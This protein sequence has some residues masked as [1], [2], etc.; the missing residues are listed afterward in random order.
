MSV[1]LRPAG[2]DTHV[3]CV[4]GRVES[5]DRRVVRDAVDLLA[6][7]TTVQGTRSADC[8]PAGGGRHALAGDQ[9]VTQ[10]VGTCAGG[11][12]ALPTAS[13]HWRLAPQRPMDPPAAHRLAM[14]ARRD[15]AQRLRW[16]R[17]HTAQKCRTDRA[18][19]DALAR[20]PAVRRVLRHRPNCWSLGLRWRPIAR[21]RT[22]CRRDSALAGSPSAGRPARRLPPLL[23]TVSRQN[24]D[25]QRSSIGT[26]SPPAST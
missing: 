6:G 7:M 3:A 12:G 5:S 14:P 19:L 17:A 1:L 20:L 4:D 2:R 24:R 13:I 11:G 16:R 22:R 18:R 15:Y 8:V 25:I 23:L 10:P 26:A 9:F 21:T